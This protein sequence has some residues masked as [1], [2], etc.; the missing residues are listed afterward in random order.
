MCEK[1]TAQKLLGLINASGGNYAAAYELAEQ[2]FDGLDPLEFD[3]E[4]ASIVNQLFQ[5]GCERSRAELFM[6]GVLRGAKREQMR[7]RV[8]EPA[9]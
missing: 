5:I 2:V 1:T 3:R 6:I 7:V 9:A 8:L 4:A